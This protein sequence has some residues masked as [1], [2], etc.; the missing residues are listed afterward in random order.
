MGTM[1]SIKDPETRTTQFEFKL[2]DRRIQKKKEIDSHE[3]RVES[4]TGISMKDPQTHDR[5]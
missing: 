1:T 5:I 2:E 4:P 3:R